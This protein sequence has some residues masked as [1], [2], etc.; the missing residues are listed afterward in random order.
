MSTPQSKYYTGTLLRKSAYT[1]SLPFMCSTLKTKTLQSQY[2]T[3]D[4]RVIKFRNFEEFSLKRDLLAIKIQNKF[5][6]TSNN[7]DT[8]SL[9]HGISLLYI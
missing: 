1:L 7:P 2:P 4:T 5:L 3:H 6:Y 8:F 9:H